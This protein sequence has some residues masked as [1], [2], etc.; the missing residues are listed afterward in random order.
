MTTL[1]ATPTRHRSARIDVILGLEGFVVVGALYGSIAMVAGLFDD[2]P[3]IPHLPFGSTALG[4]T[5]LFLVNVALPVSVIIAEAQ[6]RPWA[7]RAHLAFGAALMGWILVQVA[8]IG[9]VF[10]LQPL[11]FAIGALI[12]V[13]ALLELRA[14]RLALR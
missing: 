13:L 12:A 4:G 2:A 11:M 3:F 5:A 14:S 7:S 1:S 8:F 6:R 10:F 9:L